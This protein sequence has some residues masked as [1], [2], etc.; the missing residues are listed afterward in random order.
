MLRY[1]FN[2]NDNCRIA[3]NVHFTDLVLS[4]KRVHK[5]VKGVIATNCR[6]GSETDNLIYSLI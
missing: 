2:P 1:T 5:L 4:L 3:V 6:V